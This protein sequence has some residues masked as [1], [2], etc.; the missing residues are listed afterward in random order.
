MFYHNFLLDKTH[1]PIVLD[2]PAIAFIELPN[3]DPNAIVQGSMGLSQTKARTVDPDYT[4]QAEG[5]KS[6]RQRL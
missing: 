3:F 6:R 4:S 2:V 5:H 1:F